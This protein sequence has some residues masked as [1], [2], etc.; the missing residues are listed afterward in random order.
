MMRAHVGAYPLPVHG[1][2]PNFRGASDAAEL[3]VEHLV[4]AGW[5]PPGATVL[6]FPDH[7]LRGARKRLLERG[8]HVAVPAKHGRGY[9]LLDA[10]AVPAAASA[11]IA[12]AERHG[13]LRADPPE[14]A[15]ALVACVALAPS[16]GYLRKGYGFRLPAA[17]AELP[18]ATLIHPLQLVDRLPE[19]DGSVALYATPEGVAEVGQCPISHGPQRPKR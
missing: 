16:G 3:L 8:V 11:S 17:C 10:N 12:G 13:E 9:R 1:H 7:V 5:A 4:S 14:A 19:S 15:M 2:H 6:A 18:T